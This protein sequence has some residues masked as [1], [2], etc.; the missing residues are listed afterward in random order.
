MTTTHANINSIAFRLDQTVES[1]GH[2]PY[3]AIALAKLAADDL[4]AYRAQ[5][6]GLTEP[7]LVSQA[8]ACASYYN[9]RHGTDVTF[10]YFLGRFERAIAVHRANNPDM[11]IAMAEL[12]EEVKDALPAIVEGMDVMTSAGWRGQVV[13]ITTLCGRAIDYAVADADGEVAWFSP[14]QVQPAPHTDHDNHWQVVDRLESN[15]SDPPHTPTPEPSP[16]L[17]QPLCVQCELQPAIM[18]QLCGDCWRLTERVPVR[19]TELLQMPP[20]RRPRETQHLATPE[21][22]Y[23]LSLTNAPALIALLRCYTLTQREQLAWEFSAYLTARGH[24]RLPQFIARNWSILVEQMPW[25]PEPGHGVA[26]ELGR[27]A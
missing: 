2:A 22:I 20:R 1:Q 9:G 25:E 24:S 5:L 26:L 19:P 4:N 16:A 7:Q 12:L 10:E 3:D 13:E 18:D 27:A 8:I 21:T 6:A 15:E 23:D 17:G 11:R 14:L